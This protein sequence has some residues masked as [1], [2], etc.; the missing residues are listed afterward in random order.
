MQRIIF[1]LFI[2]LGLVGLHPSNA[3]ALISQVEEPEED[4]TQWRVMAYKSSD[5]SYL[6]TFTSST[7]SG[8]QTQCES[9]VA[10]FWPGQAYCGN[11]EQVL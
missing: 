11:P 1:A 8:A 5:N 2:L 7:A 6:E 9:W 3:S 4:I 10:D